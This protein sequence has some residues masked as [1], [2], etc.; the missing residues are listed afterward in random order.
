M[1]T[2]RDLDM[3]SFLS[4]LRF[5]ALPPEVTDKARWCLADLI[6]TAVAGLATPLAGIITDHAA[7]FFGAGSREGAPSCRP[8]TGGPIMSPAGA[9]LVVA[10]SSIS[11]I[12]MT[13]IR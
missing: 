11:S 7:D 10:W 3:R 12:P 4:E 9:A 1:L 2:S 13:G 5:A 8:M 6:G